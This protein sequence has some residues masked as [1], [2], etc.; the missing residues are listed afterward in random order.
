MKIFIIALVCIFGITA[1]AEHTFGKSIQENL[2]DGKG[3]ST[4]SD[5]SKKKYVVL[6]YSASWC[7]PCQKFTPELVKFYEKN[8]KANFEI[9]F[10]SRDRSEKDMLAYMNSK[11]MSFPALDFKKIKN[12]KELEKYSGRGIPHLAVIDENGKAVIQEVASTG[13]DKLKKLVD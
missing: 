5:L 10:I 11:K 7:G 1:Q 3:K 13:L 12:F 9:V 4:K 8:K 2:V 6:Y